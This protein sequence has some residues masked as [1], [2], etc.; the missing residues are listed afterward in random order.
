MRVAPGTRLAQELEPRITAPQ[1]C[2]PLHLNKQTLTERV[3]CDA[4]CQLLVRSPREEQDRWLSA[5]AA[6]R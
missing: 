1:H 3:Q 2:C 5:H 6:S 4:M